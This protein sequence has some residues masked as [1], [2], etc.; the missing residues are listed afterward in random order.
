MWVLKVSNMCICFIELFNN[1]LSS[2]VSGISCA[3][4]G[5]SSKLVL[6][7][8]SR[9]TEHATIYVSKQTYKHM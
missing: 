6:H 7:E 1:N 9:V 2:L 5:A 4:S 3:S 8:R